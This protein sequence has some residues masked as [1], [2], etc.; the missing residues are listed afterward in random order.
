MLRATI[1]S[2]ALL[3]G[4]VPIALASTAITVTPSSTA[5][6]STTFVVTFKAPRAGR[7]A[8]EVSG[9]AHTRCDLFRKGPGRTVAKGHIVHIKL[10]ADLRGW[11]RGRYTV[12]VD[13]YATAAPD[14]RIV[15]GR[16]AHFRVT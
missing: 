3:L 2:L 10:E 14:D 13:E 12:T 6:R 8:A 16:Q 5:K 9:P 4:C 1:V 11:C 7:Y 15:I